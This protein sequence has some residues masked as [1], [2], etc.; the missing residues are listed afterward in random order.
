MKLKEKHCYPSF[1]T[2][3]SNN[4][5]LSDA[6]FPTDYYELLRQVSLSFFF[7]ELFIVHN[8]NFLESEFIFF[9]F[10]LFKLSCILGSVE[11]CRN[12]TIFVAFLLWIFWWGSCYLLPINPYSP[13]SSMAEERLGNSLLI[14]SNKGIG[15]FI[16]WRCQI[17]GKLV[18]IIVK[19]V[20]KFSLCYQVRVNLVQVKVK[21]LASTWLWWSQLIYDSVPPPYEI[22]KMPKG[23][24]NEIPNKAIHD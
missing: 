2:Y 22:T 20:P 16:G 7:F 9:G 8:F 4:F 19:L 23:S 10:I 13:P 1:V 6:P 18:W 3:A 12:N 15:N 24:N 17:R 11:R 21:M 14:D 5:S